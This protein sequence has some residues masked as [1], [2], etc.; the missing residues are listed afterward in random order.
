MRLVE[1]EMDGRARGRCMV[2]T[3]DGCCDDEI[4]LGL[5]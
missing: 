1:N 5:Y 4:G 3:I 2:E